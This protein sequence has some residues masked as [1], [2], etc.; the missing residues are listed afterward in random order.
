MTNE[1]LD[2]LNDDDENIL[3]DSDVS[4]SMPIPTASV[5]GPQSNQSKVM[6]RIRQVR[7]GVSPDQ[8]GDS[9][10][11]DQQKAAMEMAKNSQLTANLGR[12]ANAFAAGTGYKPSNDVF[13][14]IEKTGPDMAMK[15]L[16][17]QAAIQRA[18]Q[19][20]LGREAIA[21]GNSALRDRQ[22]R[23]QERH[24]RAMEMRQGVLGKNTELNQLPEEERDAVKELAKKSANKIT[25]ANQIEAVMGGW[26]N[27]SDDQKVAQGRQMLKVLNSTEGADAVGAEEAKRLGSKLEF[28]MGNIFNSNPIQFGRDLPGFK[29]QAVDTAKNIKRAARANQLEINKRYRQYG[30]NR[31]DPAE[32]PADDKK[33]PGDSGTAYADQQKVGPDDLLMYKKAMARLMQNPNDQKAKHVLEILKGKGLGVK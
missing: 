7:L 23:E 1:L 30:I 8:V 18:I 6:D 13:D 16:G 29:E 14:S 20:R 15:Q 9:S 5:A 25:I 28:A 12:A 3:D 31:E 19:N 33:L 26:D 27:L 11:E 10:F 4:D 2:N 17:Q 24:N 21:K 32:I 22:L